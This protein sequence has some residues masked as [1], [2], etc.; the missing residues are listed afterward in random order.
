MRVLTKKTNSLSHIFKKIKS[1]IANYI[2]VL[3]V[4]RKPDKK[5]FLRVLEISI[6]FIS[7]V[8]LIGFI[9]YLFSILVGV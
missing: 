9:I 2:Y 1:T 4:A 3:K 7:F 8:G 6:T 5:E